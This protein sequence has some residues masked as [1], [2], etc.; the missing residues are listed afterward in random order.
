MQAASGWHERA[1]VEDASEEHSSHES[2]PMPI[3]MPIPVP[4]RVRGGRA[5]ADPDAA[6]CDS[7]TSSRGCANWA[8]V[9]LPAAGASS[10]LDERLATTAAAGVTH[11]SG[12]RAAHKAKITVERWR[13][14]RM[15]RWMAEDEVSEAGEVSEEIKA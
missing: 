11:V 13:R 5:D 8:L 2:V 15:R 1:T 4:V 14:T 3:P 9:V 10:V 7:S 6:T 12:L